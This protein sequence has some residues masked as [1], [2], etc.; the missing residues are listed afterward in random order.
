MK[1]EIQQ[2][3]AWLDKEADGVPFGEIGVTVTMHGGRINRVSRSSTETKKTDSQ[4]TGGN[5]RGRTRE[6]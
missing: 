2:L 4:P 1:P 5:G 6:A 3:A